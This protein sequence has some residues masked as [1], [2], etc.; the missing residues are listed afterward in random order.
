MLERVDRHAKVRSCWQHCARNGIGQACACLWQG[1]PRAY[2][3]MRH[4]D[5]FAA[6]PLHGMPLM[7]W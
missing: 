3:R 6:G 5:V 2:E 7:L 4:G 1:L